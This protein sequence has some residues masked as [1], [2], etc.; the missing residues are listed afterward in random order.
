MK[1]WKNGL[2]F[3]KLHFFVRPKLFNP[4]VLKRKPNKKIKSVKF[5]KGLIEFL[6]E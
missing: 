1:Y 6:G 3:C 2:E 4:N 5:G